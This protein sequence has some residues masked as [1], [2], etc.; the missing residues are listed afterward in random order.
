MFVSELFQEFFFCFNAFEF[1]F[2][3]K[4]KQVSVFID[5]LATFLHNGLKNSIELFFHRD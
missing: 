4:M 2:H 1:L 5:K 3:H